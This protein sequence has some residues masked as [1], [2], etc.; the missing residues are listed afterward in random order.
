[1][2]RN[3]NKKRMVVEMKVKLLTQNVDKRRATTGVAVSS[4][5]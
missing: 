1:M 2:A 3:V 5:D 4:E